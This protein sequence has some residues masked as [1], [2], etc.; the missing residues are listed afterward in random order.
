MC[1]YCESESDDWKPIARFKIGKIMGARLEMTVHVS[2]SITRVEGDPVL[3]YS[4]AGDI[5]Y[6]SNK[7]YI[8]R[9][10]YCPM[11]GQKLETW[12]DDE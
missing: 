10:K 8:S 5:C 2:K 9:I 7:S 11:C 6:V 1:K 3:V 4:P 12:E